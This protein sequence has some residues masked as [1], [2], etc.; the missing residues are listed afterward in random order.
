MRGLGIALLEMGNDQ[1]ATVALG[2]A[3]QAEPKEVMHHYA[4]AVA[5]S[6]MEL[7]KNLSLPRGTSVEQELAACID[8]DPDFA[9]VYRLQAA[10]LSRHGLLEKAANAVRKAIFLSPRTETYELVLADIELKKRDY[11]PALSLLHALK[12]SRNP[13]ISKQAEYVLSSD[14]AQAQAGER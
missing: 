6:A 8:L 9:D 7:D 2:I 1:E 14:V 11:G 5:L 4:L 3:S 12:N 10:N 13:D